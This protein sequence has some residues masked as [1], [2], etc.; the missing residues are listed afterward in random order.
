MVSLRSITGPLISKALT[1]A[2]IQHQIDCCLKPEP[3]WTGSF[4]LDLARTQQQESVPG[5]ALSAAAERSHDQLQLAAKGCC[6]DN[7]VVESFFTTLK[8]ELALDDDVTI[9]NSPQQLIREMAI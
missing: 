6:W 9:L 8:H 5:N 7:A 2:L 3:H 4:R 1:D